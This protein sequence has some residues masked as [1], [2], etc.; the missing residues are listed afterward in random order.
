MNKLFFALLAIFAAT[1]FQISHAQVTIGS[2]NEPVTGAILDLNSPGFGD[3]ARGGLLLSNVALVDTLTIPD[4]PGP[5]SK[6]I[7][8]QN[9][10]EL[11]GALVFNITDDPC[12]GLIPGVYVWEGERWRLLGLR[13]PFC[14]Y[15][16]DTSGNYSIKGKLCYDVNETASDDCS[17]TSEQSGDFQETK[18]FMYSFEQTGLNSYNNLSFHICD[19]FGIVHSFWQIENTCFI[20]F[21]DDIEEA[22]RDHKPDNPMEIKVTAHYTDYEGNLKSCNII[23]RVQDCCCG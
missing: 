2:L 23:I 13:R 14:P 18:I 21:I 7:K 1:S 11:T 10:A 22:G 4:L 16:N 3:A 17:P 6:V 5:F 9:N 20:R 19:P 8:R 12:E 15:T